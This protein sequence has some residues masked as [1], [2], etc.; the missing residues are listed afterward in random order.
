MP[1]TPRK[2]WPRSSSTTRFAHSAATLAVL[3]LLGAGANAQQA[4]PPPPDPAASAA[5]QLET[6]VVSGQGRTQ[7]LQSVPIAIQVLGADQV[8]KLGASNLGEINAHIPGLEIDANQPTQPRM[9]LRGIGTADFGIG[10]DSP[11]GIYVDGVYTGKTGGALLNFNDLKRIEVLKGPQGTLFGRNSAGGAISVVTNE[12]E[13]RRSGSGL[14]RLG[15]NGLRHVEAL[16]NQPLTESLALRA[17]LVSHKS[18]GDLRDAASGLRF[19]GENA[20]GARLALRWQASED[21]KAVLSYEHEKLDQRARPAHGLLPAVPAGTPLPYPADPA[22]FVDP[23]RAPLLNDVP[24]AKERRDFDGLTLR[25]EH[26]LPWAEFSSTTAYRRFDSRNRQDNDG[27]NNPATYLSTTNVEGNRSWQQEFRLSGKTGNADWLA[28]LSLF[29][30]R[31]TQSALVGATTT[32]LDTLSGNLLGLPLY[33]TVNGLIEAAGIPGLDLRGQGWLERM[34]NEARNRALAL[35]GDV[36][37][38]LSPANRLT[39]GLRITRDDKRFSWFNPLREAPGLDAQLAQLDAAGLFPAL[40]AMGAISQE[41][42]N[43]L[44]GAMGSN[45]LVATQGAGAAPLVVKKSWTDASPRLVLDHRFDRDLMAYGSLTRGY[46][47][48]GFNTLQVNS[49]Y[50]PEKVS[51]LELGLKGQ[52]PN[53]GLSY[54][55]ALFHYRFDNLQTLQLVPAATPGG[56]PTYQVTISDQRATGLDLEARWQASRALRFSGALELI[57]QTYSR[58]RASSGADLSGQPVGTPRLSLSLGVDWSFAAFGGQASAGLQ[59]AYAGAQR[60]NA[61]SQVQGSCLQT[62]TLRVGGARQR[63]D[64]R[65]AWDSA[66]QRWGIALVGTNLQDKRYINKIWYEGAPLGSAYATLSRPRSLALELRASY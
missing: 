13:F 18:D 55:A 51:N 9:S 52:F 27:T 4:A 34:S 11:V 5:Q 16:L 26:A 61:E 17:S 2:P 62:P 38:Q 59:A 45:A 37:W 66:D 44:R 25:I 43:M 50:E 1:T 64:G 39:T 56:L 20:W 31:A 15:E 47:A 14:A 22:R 48:G 53:A 30:E 28:G 54:S 40:V 10:T 33:S 60:C 32:S 58:G 29:D 35:Y 24:D 19:G 57:D 7:Q 36:I 8:R 65:L 46:Q 63:L 6:V 12:P 23:R 49:R 41:Q 21:T 3:S 42:A